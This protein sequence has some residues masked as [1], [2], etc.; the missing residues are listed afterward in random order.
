MVASVKASFMVAGDEVVGDLYLP[1]ADVRHSGVIV[2]GPM[3]SVKEQV[4]GVY[5]RALAERGIAALAIDHRHYGASGG[6]PR[7]YEHAQHK[8]ED[9]KAAIGHLAGHSAIDP[10]RVGA[11]GVCLGCGYAAWAAVGNPHVRALGLV[12]GYY[13]D[14]VAMRANDA[15]GFDAKVAQGRLARQ[16]F[17]ETGEVETIP[18]AALEGDAAM[19]TTDTVDYYTRRAVVPSY[20][21]AFAIMSREHFLPFDVQAAAGGIAIPVAMVHSENALSPAW[22]RKFHGAIEAPKHIEWI[23]SRG[24]TDFYDNPVLVGAASDILA[25]AMRTWL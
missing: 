7:Q 3:T 2:A 12:A 16:R 1:D 10:A 23:E 25:R 6:K 5:A 11:V 14:P 20:R 22:A 9:L 8:I 24:Q 21:N 19:Q 18:A 15:P 4:T 17:E 13:R